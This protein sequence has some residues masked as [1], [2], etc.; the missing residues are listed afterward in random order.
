MDDQGKDWNT[1]PNYERYAAHLDGLE[2]TEEQARELLEVLW[3]IMSTF[4]D[5]GFGIEPTQLICGWIEASRAESAAHAEPVIDLKGRKT[6]QNFNAV[7][8]NGAR[9]EER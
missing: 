9:E 5:Y 7:A 4:A 1:N 3:S 2:L 6:S 8:P